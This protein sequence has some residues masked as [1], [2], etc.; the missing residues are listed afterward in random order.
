MANHKIVPSLWYNKEAVEAAKLYASI[1]PDSRIDKVWALPTESPSGPAGTVEIVEY[2]LFGQPFQAMSA[3]PLDP[4][5]HAVS[6]TVM[7]ESQQ[8][9]DKY[10][11]AL[12]A[13]GGK[14]EQCGWVK[15]K[16]GVLWQ[17]TPAILSKLMADP[18]KVKAKRVADAM[19]KMVKLDIAALK[20]A[21]EG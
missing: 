9:I 13:G 11:D 6:F 20:R 1:F 17:I 3:G 18:D 19:M 7:C 16:Y 10:W 12:L 14:E 8:E 5:N 21:F 15:D 4:F 2:T